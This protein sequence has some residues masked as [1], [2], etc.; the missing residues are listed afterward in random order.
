MALDRNWFRHDDI[1]ALMDAVLTRYGCEPLKDGKDY[2]GI[3]HHY[4]RWRAPQ[5]VKELIHG[6]EVSTNNIL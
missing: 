3:F 2:Y 5:P 6:L 4:W 1:V